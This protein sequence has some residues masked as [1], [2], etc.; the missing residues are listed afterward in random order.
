MCPMSRKKIKALS[1]K[2]KQVESKTSKKKKQ[3]MQQK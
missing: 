1:N 3:K 2:P